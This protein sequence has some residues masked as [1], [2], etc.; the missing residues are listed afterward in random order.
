M[1]ARTD[2]NSLLDA[3][4]LSESMSPVLCVLSDISNTLNDQ[5]FINAIRSKMAVTYDDYI[6][7][8][9]KT[10]KTK[11]KSVHPSTRQIASIKSKIKYK[12]TPETGAWRQNKS[13]IASVVET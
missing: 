12:L 8:N 4:E 13:T 11:T 3:L 7:S 2:S 6:E 9:R 1:Q 10:N 5:L